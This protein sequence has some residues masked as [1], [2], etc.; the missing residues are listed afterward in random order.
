MRLLRSLSYFAGILIG[1]VILLLYF[2]RFLPSSPAANVHAENVA[3]VRL[4]GH[5]HPKILSAQDLGAVEP[6]EKLSLSLIFKP[7]SSQQLKLERF[8]GDIQN[9]HSSQFHKWITPEEYAD[10]YGMTPQTMKDVANW[11]AASGIAVRET[12]P[13]RNQLSFEATAAQAEQL[14]DV[15]LRHYRVDGKL[16]YSNNAEPTVPQ[17]FANSVVG[18]RGL[19]DLRL[20]PRS[21]HNR[22]RAGAAFNPQFTSSISGNTFLAPDDFATIYDVKG[23][24]SS[25]IDGTGQKIAIVG[26]TNI[27]LSDVQAFRKASGLAQNDPQV[28]LDG[29]DPG[30]LPDDMVEA[31]LDVEWSGAIAKGATIL[32]V[33]S[34]DVLN[35]FAYAITHNVA[36]V[37][38]ISY[39]A[40]ESSL[41]ASDV[42][43]LQSLTQQANAQGMTVL[44]ASGDSGA[45]DCDYS[46]RAAAMGLAVDLP[47]ALP[48][49]TGVGGTRFVE[50]DN[51]SQFWSSTNN[52]LNGSATKYIPEE[53]W[54]DTSTDG[55]LAASGGGVSSLFSKPTWQTGAGVPN[56]GHRDVPDVALNASADHDGYLTCSDGS[57]VNGFRDS[58][59]FLFV[60]GGTSAGS[61]TFAGIVALINQ[62]YGAG[63]GNINPTLYALAS[64]AP[65]A[66]HDI[67][68]GSNVVPCIN[69]S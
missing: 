35:S 12:A 4:T 51:A 55:T 41:A 27:K 63:Q 33:N 3:K 42:Q 66:F 20:R 37:I 1:P 56:D 30:I 47:A 7:S 40:C 17:A 31:D 8:L 38:S 23:L 44:A 16:H 19:H 57:C 46:K 53:G 50:G 59:D 58:D 43:T 54:N 29:S 10:I 5:V 22:R 28:I 24:Y 65:V 2:P 25:G 11:L 60:V 21:I 62:K 39:G 15:E 6:S 61:P 64:S 67:T 36:P 45:V 49:V 52:S 48:S 9:P 34:T 26:Q 32:Y 14:F 69:A 13:S 18:V 68:T